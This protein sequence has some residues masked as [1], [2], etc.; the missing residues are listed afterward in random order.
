MVAE[1]GD[2]FSALRVVH[3][4]ARAPRGRPV[5]VRDLVD[6]LN[7]DYMDW[8]FSRRVV[9]DTIVQLQA[10]WQTDYRTRDGILLESGAAGEELTFEDSNRI[11]SWLVRQAE[12]LAAECR[13]RLRD[14]ARSEGDLP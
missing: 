9:V 1:S 10:N 11:E 2:P 3:L 12:R 4:L 5:R 6:R 7:G 8:S 14:F 13:D